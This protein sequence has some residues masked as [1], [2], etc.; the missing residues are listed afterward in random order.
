MPVFEFQV[1]ASC[2]PVCLVV[3]T[4]GKKKYS[5]FLVPACG[6]GCFFTNQEDDP[7]VTVNPFTSQSPQIGPATF[8]ERFCIIVGIQEDCIGFF[9]NLFFKT[10]EMSEPIFEIFGEEPLVGLY[11]LKTS[12]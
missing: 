7:D 4:Y 6:V 8:S 11:H 1:L 12:S 5:L 3:R 10:A 2:F 9:L